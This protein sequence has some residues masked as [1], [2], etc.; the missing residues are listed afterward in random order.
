MSSDPN[1]AQPTR[2]RK[3]A[4]LTVF[5][6]LY[7]IYVGGQS[8]DE[9]TVIALQRRP[10]AD[11][12]LEFFN[13]EVEGIHAH[14]LELDKIIGLHLNR[15]WSPD[16]LAVVDLLVLRIATFELFYLPGIPPKVSIIEAVNLAKTYGSAES[17]RFVHGVLGSIYKSSPKVDWQ[18]SDEERRSEPDIGRVEPEVEQEQIIEEGTA[19][20]DEIVQAGRWVIRR[21]DG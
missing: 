4:R 20:H 19:D 7:T 15:G 18:P 14:Q 3:L 2:S 1:A 16:R 8:P 12:A 21:E 10:L 9:A 17:G 6:A 5:E 13:R 11:D